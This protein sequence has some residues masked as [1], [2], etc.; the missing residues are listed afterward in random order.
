MSQQ[1][2]RALR[3]RKSTYALFVFWVV[4]M[5]IVTGCVYTP[6]SDNIVQEEVRA[7]LPSSTQD[8]PQKD[9]N[10]SI[11]AGA[12]DPVVIKKYN[13]PDGFVYLDDVIPSAEYDIRYYGDN[14]FIG[15]P[16]D[17]YNSPLAILTDEAAQAL[18]A[19]SEE[20]EEKG[21][22]LKIFDAYRPAKAVAHFIEWA[23]DPKDTSMKNIF[24]PNI[25]KSK[26]FKLGYLAKKSGHS[27]GSTVDLTLV[28][29]NTG[30]EV[31]MGGSFDLL[32]EISHHN[33]KLISAEQ[34]ANRNML[35]D[36]MNRHGFKHYSKEWWH[37]TLRKEPYPDQYFD[38]DVE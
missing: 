12:A 1:G 18:K 25:D 2:G 21:Y 30:Q 15:K 23:Q 29:K 7:D 6:A 27:R 38:F 11:E 24:Y 9:T 34:A 26:L 31:N 35:K 20:L 5:Q 14:N 28:D 33:T 3:R 19:V 10:V 8:K 36:A 13:L 37:Y 22:R 17:G 4:I 16:V 32:D